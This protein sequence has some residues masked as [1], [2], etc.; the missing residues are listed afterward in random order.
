MTC[1]GADNQ[2][3]VWPLAPTEVG[4][5]PEMATKPSKFGTQPPGADVAAAM[6]ARLDSNGPA[7]RAGLRQGDLIRSVNGHAV[8]DAGALQTYVFSKRPGA[9]LVMEVIRA[10]NAGITSTR[11]TATL[12]SGA[13]GSA[14]PIPCGARGAA[15]SSTH[16]AAQ[17]ELPTPGGAQA[18][19]RYVRYADP[20]EGAFTALAPTGWRVGG[21]LV[22]YGPI[23]IAPF[24]QAMTPDG[25]I[26]VQLGD[27]HIKDYCDIPGWRDGQLYTPGTSVEF[28]RRIQ[29]AEQYAHS[30]GLGF[31]KQLGCENPVFTASRSVENPPGVTTIPQA[32]VDTNLT[33]FNCQRSGQGYTGRV[34]VTVQAYRLPTTGR[35]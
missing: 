4:W 21:R 12:T 5:L 23:S 10:T 13:S 9:V 34:M 31:Q 33:Q 8:T 17:P 6:V 32:R 35:Q 18:E 30:Y 1:L 20:A 11:V 3:S 19:V 29:S 16:A 2:S 14:S 24:V 22:R 27:W 26:F 15:L 28:V 7:A 25:T